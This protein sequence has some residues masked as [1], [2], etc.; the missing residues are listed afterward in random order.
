MLNYYQC[1]AGLAV[2]FIALERF[3]PRVPDQRLL[4]RGWLSDAAYIA[5][6]SKYVGILLG[7]VTVLWLGRLNAIKRVRRAAEEEP[8][9]GGGS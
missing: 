8:L 9:G 4:R 2:V 7:Y 3:W 6:N 5:F 1:L